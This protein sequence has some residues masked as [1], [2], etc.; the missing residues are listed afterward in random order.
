MV[1]VEEL[2]HLL[3]Q[4]VQAIEDEVD[5]LLRQRA[6]DL[7]EPKRQQAEQ[8]DLRG[9]RLRR[10][11]ADLDPAARV[12][13]RV[14]LAGDLRAHHVRDRE[15]ARAALAREPYRVDGVARLARLRDPDHERV[16][17][18]HG[19]AVDPFA[20]DVGLD[21]HARPLFDDV[22]ADDARVVRGAG[23]DDHD[24][25]QVAHLHLRQAERLEHQLVAADA[26]ADRLAHRLGL[27]VDLLEH[28]RLVAALL[29]FLVVPVE[30]LHLEVLALDAV[31]E[32][33]DGRRRDLDDLA[34][35]GEHRAA[36]LAE[37][38]GDVR[39]E[40]VLALAEPDDERRLATNADEQVGKIVV[41]HDDREVA[42]EQ[43]IDTR[44]GCCEIAVELAL[45]QMH[46]DFGVGLG[47]E[48]VTLG[49]QLRLELAV[50]LHDA[51]EDDGDLRGVAAG[52]RMR[53]LLG[54]AA[55]RG[56]A[57]VTEAVARDGAV[58]AGHID[59]ILEVSDRPDVV[60]AVVLPE[61]DPGRVVAPVLEAPQP[62][63]EE[64][65]GLSRP[66]VSDDPAHLGPTF[67]PAKCAKPCPKNAMSPATL[68][69][70]AVAV[71]SAE[72]H[73]H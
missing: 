63:Q 17:R 59:E 65:L 72:L 67:F 46:D 68:P 7:R 73:G 13:R 58:R 23:G 50:V 2:R 14:D 18:Q 30:L 54:D 61:R 60:E 71:R 47:A 6:T 40:E 8:R 35:V 12:E 1:A 20:R 66:D 24:A 38:G 10:G 37:E 48:R 4:L 21:G 49:D 43:R 16:L 55:V 45:E 3:G 39:G 19:V 56:P 62:L 29:G 32:E 22:P 57:R 42:F 9:E 34:V 36:R 26:V 33:T 69:P 51:V 27:L 31:L 41:D 53:V 15:R 52:E 44:N 11:D 25:A 64:R 70:R 5:L 28:E